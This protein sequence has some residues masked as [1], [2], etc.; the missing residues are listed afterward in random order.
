MDVTIQ[1]DPDNDSFYLGFSAGNLRKG[2]VARSI[3]ATEDISLDLDS[4]GRLLG[5]DVMNATQ[6]LG[7][8]YLEIRFDALMGVKEA[9]ALLGVQKSNFV[10]DLASREDFPVPV[11]ELATGRVWLKSQVQDFAESRKRRATRAS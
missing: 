3:R 11:V 6:S 1:T 8:D 10:R 5:L 2:S 4:E 9:A 7:E